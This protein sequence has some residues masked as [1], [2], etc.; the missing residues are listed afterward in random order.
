MQL[1]RQSAR[2]P[3]AEV[4]R[5]RMSS[6]SCVSGLTSEVV[7]SGR[8]LLVAAAWP[9]SRPHRAFS[10][11]L[12]PICSLRP[13]RYIPTLSG[14]LLSHANHTFPS[15]SANILNDCP[16]AITDVTFDAIIWAPQVGQTLGKQSLCCSRPRCL[17]SEL[18]ILLPIVL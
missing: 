10:E 4:C 1:V 16:F 13:L 17:R 3:S 9:T 14:V 11:S 2:L 6:A 8:E 12:T 15:D 18:I 7:V 5:L